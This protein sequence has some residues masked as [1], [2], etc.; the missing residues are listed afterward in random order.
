MNDN[1]RKSDRK[2]GFTLIELLVVISIIAVLMAIMMPSLQKARSLAKR[3]QCSASQRGIMTAMQLYL[4][5]FNNV[6]FPAQNGERWFDLGKGSGNTGKVLYGTER[7]ANGNATADA[8]RAYWGTMY[9]KY[10]AS[11]ELFEC[12]SKKVDSGFWNIV[13][14]GDEEAFR[15]SDYGLNGYTCWRNPQ[16]EYQMIYSPD[17]GH[18]RFDDFSRPSD[19]IAFHDHWEPML[20]DNG[21][22]YYINPTRDDENLKQWRDFLRQDPQRYGESVNEC[23]RHDDSSNIMW[24]DGH[25]SNLKRTTGED[26]EYVWYTGGLGGLH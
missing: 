7:D 8:A 17:D 15:Y 26:V 13:N 21:D 6:F 23:W 24:L 22:M 25:V 9:S 18:R 5:D 14:P 20:D 2:Q 12:P 16:N 11:K 4:N 10:G 1:N 19:T 3:A